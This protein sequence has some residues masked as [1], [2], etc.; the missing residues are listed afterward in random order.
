MEISHS[1]CKKHKKMTDRLKKS[2]RLRPNNRLVDT[3]TKRGSPRGNISKE[4]FSKPT[5]TQDGFPPVYRPADV[6]FN[7][8][9]WQTGPEDPG[10]T[11]EPDQRGQDG[12]STWSGSASGSH[13]NPTHAP[14]GG[15]TDSLTVE[16]SCLIVLPCLSHFPPLQSSGWLTNSP[17]TPPKPNAKDK[18]KVMPMLPVYQL[19]LCVSGLLPAVSHCSAVW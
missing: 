8:G 10:P 9:S 19:C 16:T 15:T 13:H 2:C 4:L 1:T 17:V 12:D 6:G 14:N 11:T 7:G 5:N 18:S 3:S